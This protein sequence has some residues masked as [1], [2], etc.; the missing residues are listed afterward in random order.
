MGSRKVGALRKFI[1]WKE[2]KSLEKE[3][4]ETF[5]VW[6]LDALGLRYTGVGSPVLLNADFQSSGVQPLPK[7]YQMVANGVFSSG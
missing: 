7:S 1:S 4:S 3:T 5:V 6:A 2:K